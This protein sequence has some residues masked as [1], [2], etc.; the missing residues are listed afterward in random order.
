MASVKGQGQFWDRVTEQVQPLAE[1]QQLIEALIPAN[2]IRGRD[3]L[4]AGCG[5]GDYSAA[6]SQLGART[7]AGFDVSAG[8]LRIA[9]GKASAAKFLQASLSEL[10]YRAASFDVIWSS[11]VL[12]Y[13]PDAQ[14]ALREI[15]RVLRPGG[16]A[17]IH[18]LRCGFW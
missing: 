4:D 18:T 13:V 7:V 5:A 10:P 9:Q 8:S 14:S 12:H 11:G 6:L 1:A 16:I 15:M 2:E 3:M 17:V